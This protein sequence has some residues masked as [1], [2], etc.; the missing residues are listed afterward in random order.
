MS[1]SISEREKACIRLL[2]DSFLKGETYCTATPDT[3]LSGVKLEKTEF[4]S[5]MQLMKSYEIIRSVERAGNGFRFEIT[6]IAVHKAREIAAP[7]NLLEK[8]MESYKSN[9]VA[10]RIVFWFI[11]VSSATVFVAGVLTI[12]EKAVDLHKKLGG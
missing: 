7:V 11:I 1:D 6:A 8:L 5:L 2:A 12:I 10:A 9:P 3:L 4:E